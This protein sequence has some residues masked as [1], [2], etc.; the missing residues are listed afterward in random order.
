M[1]PAGFLR[2]MKRVPLECTVSVVEPKTRMLCLKWEVS[3]CKCVLGERQNSDVDSA[4]TVTFCVN[5]DPWTLKTWCFYGARVL[6]QPPSNP[7]LQ[8]RSLRVR[9]RNRQLNN[10]ASL[11]QHHPQNK[12][13][14]S[15]H[16]QSS[17]LLQEPADP[18]W[19][20]NRRDIDSTTRRR[21]HVWR[22]QR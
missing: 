4:T 8:S 5:D 15:A 2:R 16:S 20:L 11:T 12:L 19:N 18:V 22:K 6:F 7:I 17:S 13:D 21:G 1:V 3:S 14:Y 10:K 9:H